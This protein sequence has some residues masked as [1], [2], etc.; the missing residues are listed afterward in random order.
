MGWACGPRLSPGPTR[1]VLRVTMPAGDAAGQRL[2]D[3]VESA[4]ATSE[5]G[6]PKGLARVAQWGPRINRS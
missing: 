4:F 1:R 3:S 6:P 2:P 5:Q